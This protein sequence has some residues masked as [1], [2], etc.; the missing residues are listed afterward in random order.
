MSQIDHVLQEAVA[1]GSVPG[2]VA[3]VADRDGVRYR[4]AYGLQR[5]DRPDPMTQDTIFRI[6]SWT[7]SVTT[8]AIMQL[9][10]RGLVR[11]DQPVV[12]VAPEFGKIQLLAGIDGDRPI[13]RPPSSPVTIA[14]L[15]THTSGLAYDIWSDVVLRYQELTG[16][17]SVLSGLRESL[18]SPLI[19]EPGTGWAYGPGIDWLGQVV[20]AVTGERIDRYL[21][22]NI[23][24][25]LGMTSTGFRVA[26]GDRARLAA[27]HARAEDGSLTPLDFD[28]TT[29]PGHI[30]CGHGL[31]STVDDYVRFLQ[32]FL[33]DG[34][35]NGEQ[36]IRPQTV[37]QM[38]ENRIGDVVPGVMRSTMPHLSNDAE[39]F[40]GLR[41][42]HSV[43]FQ[44]ILEQPPGM[45]SA[46]SLSWAGLF[47]VFYWW[48]PTRQLVAA[49]ASQLLPFQDPRAMALYGE[50]ERAVYRSF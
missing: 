18:F 36:I 26:D 21:S 12:E 42:G 17:P 25:R 3:V 19:F 7:K 9:V 35:G 43:G 34:R 30:L 14:H 15:A 37:R 33:H 11:L 2:V 13:L 31:Y 40:P 20:E 44:T 24:R 10:E 47:N 45:R 39:F 46:G 49:I 38:T 5:T 50:F 32:I 4:G 1:A 16:T 6:S 48:D 8:T 41:K 22:A 28:W 27:I 23:F 29:D